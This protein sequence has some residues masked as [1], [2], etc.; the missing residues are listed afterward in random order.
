MGGP[1]S[2]V[3]ATCLPLNSFSLLLPQ[4]EGEGRDGGAEGAARE[5]HG[6]GRR[7]GSGHELLRSPNAQLYFF[8]RVAWA[9]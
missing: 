8:Q 7:S 4:G 6:E 2:L 9:S 1:F 5:W 3:L